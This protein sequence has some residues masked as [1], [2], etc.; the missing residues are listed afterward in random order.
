M[1]LVILYYVGYYL[2]Y[3]VW[4]VPVGRMV[5]RVGYHT[6]ILL[7]NL[8]Y[9]LWLLFILL[10]DGNVAWAGGA[11]LMNGLMSFYWIPYHSLF[12]LDSKDGHRGGEVGWAN[13]LARA[14]GVLG[15]FLGGVLITTMGFGV[16]YTVGIVMILIS[17]LAVLRMHHHD[18][19]YDKF[20]WSDLET[21]FAN[22]RVREQLIR[23]SARNV[24][25]VVAQGIFWPI[26]IFFIVGASYEKVGLLSSAALGLSLVVIY[27]VGR[28][29]DKGK[30]GR[31]YR[32]GV[33][34]SV[35]AW[36]MRALAT[37]GLGVLLAD[38]FSKVIS[39]F[40][41]VSLESETY[42]MIK[43][44]PSLTRVVLRELFLDLVKMVVIAGFL[45]WWVVFAN[46]WY[47]FVVAGLWNLV[48]LRERK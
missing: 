31:W 34:G 27:I 19:R 12:A 42:E 37:T 36:G 45:V 18:H 47:I 29:T 17:T 33:V 30:M 15:P 8:A 23:Y 5:H 21:E 13:I 26:M 32:A 11:L 4:E 14:A 10:A 9:A 16:T 39:P 43:R 25:S 44:G 22:W 6:S 38:S 20:G 41:W 2:S 40:Y 7:G 35:A 1:G 3:V 48:A 24:E 28:F 46:F